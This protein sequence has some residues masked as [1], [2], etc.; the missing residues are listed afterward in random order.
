MADLAGGEPVAHDQ[1][2]VEHQAGADALADLDREQAAVGVAAEAQLGEGDGVGVVGDVDAD[3]E[4]AGQVVGQV[5]VVPPAVGGLEDDARGVDDA[6]ATHADTE[7][8][9]VG[10]L[11]QLRGK[12]LDEVEGGGACAGPAL[13]R[14]AVEDLA[15]QV[16][17]RAPEHLVVAEV[18]GDGE[19]GVGDDAEEGGGLADPLLGAGAELL[20]QALAQ[21]LAGQVAD[22]HA[23]EMCGAGDVGPAER[24][25]AEDR[26]Q[27]EGPVVP[28]GVAGHGLAP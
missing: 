1:V 22:G 2:A 5:E 17:E 6:G 10:G 4:A 7:Q 25:V 3:P 15:G 11:G 27:H 8:R 18:E 12:G 16:D 19:A 28:A 24:A 20:D 21:Q 9:A 13:G 14:P 26:A 23:G